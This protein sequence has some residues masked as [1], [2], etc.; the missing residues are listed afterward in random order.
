V[1][2]R[3][4]K[5]HFTLLREFSQYKLLSTKGGDAVKLGR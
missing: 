2:T 3:P 5:G 4:Q 1:S